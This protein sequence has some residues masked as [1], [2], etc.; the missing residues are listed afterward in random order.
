MKD[1]KA[2]QKL[3]VTLLSEATLKTS[4]NL[5]R[6]ELTKAISSNIFK[7]YY[8]NKKEL[9]GFCLAHGL[10]ANGSKFELAERINIYLRTGIAINPA[11]VKRCGKWDNAQPITLTTPVINYKNDAKTKEFFVS[12]IRSKFHFN[13][14]LRS[15]AKTPDLDGSIT[16]ADLVAGWYKA[17]DAKKTLPQKAPIGK[18]FQFNQFQRDFYR[19]E[20][21][22]SRQ[23]CLDA[24]K[25]VRS[26]P[27]NAT[28]AHYIILVKKGEKF[29]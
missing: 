18:Q 20:I 22:K 11:A 10:V 15:F 23:Q 16:Y 17:E 21:G 1:L 5:K 9:V 26:A 24:W 6:P 27:G 29:E 4:L 7:S 2:E 14:Y 8:W 13:D 25:L 12:Q 28:Y 19:N 3:N